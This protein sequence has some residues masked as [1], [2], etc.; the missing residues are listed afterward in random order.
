VEYQEGVDYTISNNVITKVAGSSIPN[1]TSDNLK[2]I[3]IP[4]QYHHV[5]S[6]TNVLTD[7]VIMGANSVYT[8]S[9]FYY[10][11]QIFVT[12]VHDIKDI[13]DETYPQ[14]QGDK[15]SKTIA[16]LKAKETLRITGIGDSVLEGCSV[17]SYFNHE[18]FMPTFIELTRKELARR[19]DTEVILNNISVGG[20]MSSWGASSTQINN[21]INT[22]PDLLILHF[23]I[24]DAGGGVSPNAYR[25][26][27]E[28]IVLE[29]LSHLPNTEI[30]MLTAASPNPEIY[31]L[32]NMGTMYEKIKVIANA[33]PGVS[34]VD[35]NKVTRDLLTQKK[36]VDLT[37]NGINHV[38][39]FT[40]RVYLMSL[41]STLIK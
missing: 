13:K 16:K 6:I 19:Y 20:T 36:Y 23:G 2:G 1:L 41:L 22:A 9:P 8:E 31:D 29:V 24:N 37:A 11:N 12:Y 10:G 15:L 4:A 34:V 7:Y 14:Y 5:S 32:D 26:N 33:N 18:P 25:D 30:I 28:Y 17:S 27:M 38:N 3:N 40:A 35:V 39:D 21:I